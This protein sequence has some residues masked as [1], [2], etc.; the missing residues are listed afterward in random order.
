V[1]IVSRPGTHQRFGGAEGKAGPIVRDFCINNGLM[2]RAIRDSI[3]MCP[4]LVISHEEID[5][6]LSIIRRSLDEAEP[7]LVAIGA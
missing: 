5:R 2:V 1:E 6:M 7:E 4:P 3:V